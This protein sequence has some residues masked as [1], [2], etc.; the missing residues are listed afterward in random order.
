MSNFPPTGTYNTPIYPQD[1]YMLDYSPSGIWSTGFATGWAVPPVG[2]PVFISA[3]IKDHDPPGSGIQAISPFQY[4]VAPMGSPFTPPT[5][6]LAQ[7][8][9]ASWHPTSP[10]SS[11]SL[12]PGQLSPRNSIQEPHAGKLRSYSE[13]S[14]L[15]TRLRALPLDKQNLLRIPS[16]RR[17]ATSPSTFEAMLSLMEFCMDAERRHTTAEPDGALTDRLLQRLSRYTSASGSGSRGRVGSELYQCMWPE[18]GRQVSRKPNAVAHL[19]SHCHYKPFVCQNCDH[20]PRFRYKH[21]YT[22]HC[23]N[24]VSD[25]IPVAVSSDYIYGQRFGLPFA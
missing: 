23:R 4:Q 11:T 1:G 3:P 24:H 8:P 25:S 17:G 6:V 22:R 9:P 15:S 2:G 19:M 18:C 5:N 20:H 7:Q 16:S 10:I 12:N 21:D 13:S 14:S